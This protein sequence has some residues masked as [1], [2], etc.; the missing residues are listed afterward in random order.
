VR[1]R[2]ASANRGALYAPQSEAIPVPEQRPRYAASKSAPKA[3]MTSRM[4]SAGPAVDP[5]VTGS[6]R[7]TA[8]TA[9]RAQDTAGPKP[10]VKPGAEASKA[11]NEQVAE[12]APARTGIDQFRWPVRG[13]V[14]SSFGDKTNAGRNDGIDISVPEGTAV[15]AAENGVVVYSGSELE[16]FGNLVLVRHSDGWVSAYAYNKTLEVKRGDEVR[17]GQIIA[18]SGRTGSAE[19]PKLHFELRRNSVPLDP[20]KYLGGA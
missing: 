2:Y 6:A 4:A 11:R 17:R 18:R 16:G 1:T 5:V 14:I 15:K 19:L 9:P 13:R 20:L 12:A 7:D 10:Y 3:P 8:A